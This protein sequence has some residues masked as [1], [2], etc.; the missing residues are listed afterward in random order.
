[1]QRFESLLI[2]T[3]TVGSYLIERLAKVGKTVALYHRNSEAGRLLLASFSKVFD[4]RSWHRLNS[5][6]FERL[7]ER[8]RSLTHI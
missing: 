2:G 4:V 6:A 3:G 8:M 5:F 1:M 7:G